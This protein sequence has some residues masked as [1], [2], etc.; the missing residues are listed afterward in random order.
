MFNILIILFIIYPTYQKGYYRTDDLPVVFW[1]FKVSK[2]T[3]GVNSKIVCGAICQAFDQKGTKCNAWKLKDE[4]CEIAHLYILKE[5]EEGDIREH[6]Y[7]EDTVQPISKSCFGGENCCSSI[8]KCYFGNGDC[9]ADEDC[10]G[11]GLICGNKNCP[12]EKGGL[13]DAEDDCC[14]GKCSLNSPC[15]PGE[16][17]CLVDDDC[18]DPDFNMC[19]LTESC[20]S[21]IYFPLDEFPF[22]KPINYLPNQ[23][24]C[25]RRC[26]K[27]NPCSYDTKGCKYTEDCLSGL[28]CN[29]SGI[30]DDINE[31]DT[32]GICGN[33]TICENIIGNY[34]CQCLDGYEGKFVSIYSCSV[35][36]DGSKTLHYTL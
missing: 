15:S 9:D 16:G 30:C 2:S 18:L 24:C 20:V 36:P 1:D 21:S 19:E 25:R 31:C 35:Y 10:W 14:T 23:N 33:N 26:Y 12:V 11:L 6:I 22:N 13:W 8:N 27:N 17:R 7:V 34:N 5:Y 29:V 32:I 3:P 28:Q 4:I